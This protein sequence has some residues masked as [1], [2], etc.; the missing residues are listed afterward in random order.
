MQVAACVARATTP[1]L[2]TRVSESTWEEDTKCSE[3]FF[4]IQDFLIL[5][6]AVRYRALPVHLSVTLIQSSLN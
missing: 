5:N 3:R 2:V 4:R 6:K 1:L